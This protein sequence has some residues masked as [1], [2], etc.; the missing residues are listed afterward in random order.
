MCIRDRF[1]SRGQVIRTTDTKAEIVGYNASQR[2]AFLGKIGRSSYDGNDYHTAKFV[3][4]SQLNTSNKKYGTACL[5]LSPG[6]S[7]HTFVSGVTNA[8]IASNGATGSFT[9]ATGTT[10]NPFTGDMVI[11]IGTHTLT[12]SNKVTILDSGVVFTCAQDGNT[13][14]KAYPRATDPSSGLALTITAETD[15]TITVNVGAVAIDG[16]LTVPTSTEFGFGTGA[17]TIECWIKLNT[18]AAG[19]KTIF[20][21][22]SGATELAPYLYVDG[23]NIKYFNN[24]SVTITGATNLVVGTWYHVALSRTGTSTKLF[25]NGTQEGSTYSD[26][27]DYGSTKPIRIG[28]DYAGSA[29]TTGY[30]DDLRVSNTARYT[31]AFTAPVGV[32]QGDAD[33]KLLIH[34]DGTD[35]QTYTEDW[36]GGESLTTGEEINND[37][38]LETTRAIVDTLMM[39][40]LHLMPLQLLLVVLIRT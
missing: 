21:M 2:T 3:G 19:S 6:A 1:L 16:Y 23:A 33:A 14:N 22:R 34:F 26:S 11:E 9:A 39:A 20:D 25:L 12:T 35:G 28:G 18:I 30:V 40:V 17:F 31:T 4:S 24:G 8:I 36:S 27:S 32:L 37:S 15:T 29:I 5:A 10:Y 13:A 38:I 7:A